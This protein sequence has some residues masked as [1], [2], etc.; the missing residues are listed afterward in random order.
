MPIINF[1][2]YFC[3]NLKNAIIQ[4]YSQELTELKIIRK[5]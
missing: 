5:K 4:M 1:N 3:N 2:N